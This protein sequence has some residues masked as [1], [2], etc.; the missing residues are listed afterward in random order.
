MKRILLFLLLAL[1]AHASEPIATGEWSAPVNG[2]RGRLLYLKDE[3]YE[4]TRIALIYVE[5]ENVGHNSVA[6]VLWHLASR[7]RV[8]DGAGQNV[9]NKTP[10]VEDYIGTDLSS[11]SLYLPYDSTLRLPISV[12][13]GFGFK[14]NGG[15]ALQ[16]PGSEFWYFPPDTQGERFLKGTF[17]VPELKPTDLEHRRVDMGYLPDQV[18]R[19]TLELP[20]VKIPLAAPK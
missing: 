5:L 17:S 15:L 6:L 8:P 9:E 13:Y 19:G 1:S 3:P 4:G 18:W 14:H 10:F 11:M 16:F 12:A 7:F 20:K 2:L